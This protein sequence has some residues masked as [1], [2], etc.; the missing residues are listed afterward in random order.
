MFKI[1]KFKKIL[2][3]NLVLIKEFNKFF[4]VENFGIST[5]L[6]WQNEL[7]SILNFWLLF[8]SFFLKINYLFNLNFLNSSLELN[9]LAIN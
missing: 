4:I 1:L 8:D 9:L 2:N 5:Y 7:K 3:E 6:I